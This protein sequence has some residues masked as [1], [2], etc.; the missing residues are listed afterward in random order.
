MKSLEDR[1]TDVESAVAHLQ[2]YYEAQNEVLLTQGA[3]LDE[4]E[5]SI[6]EIVRR[7]ESI[8]LQLERPR[9]PED[10]KPPH[11]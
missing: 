3:K 10:E 1:I 9:N 8:N 4:L 5:N 2:H 7:L 6:R 11:Y